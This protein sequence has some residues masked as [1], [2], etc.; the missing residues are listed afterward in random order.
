MKSVLYWSFILSAVAVILSI[1]AICNTYPRQI[2]LGLDYQGWITGVLALLVT[3]LIGLNIF[4]L[5]DFKN[6]EKEI[7]ANTASMA[8][9]LI[10]INQAEIS[11]NGVMEQTIA[12]IYYA[13]LGYKDPLGF[14]YK[15]ILHSLLALYY[16]SESDDIKN[17]NIIVAT[18]LQTISSFESISIDK[19]R[20]SDFY[21]WLHKIKSPE[22]ISRFNDLL[23]CIAGMKVS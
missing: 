19:N 23:E 20:K 6:K 8:K 17:C 18:M 9:A 21:V 3:A 4:S 13:M 15:Y 2:E 12:S 22:K 1:V 16:L 7:D 11:N 10:T 5:V 14:E